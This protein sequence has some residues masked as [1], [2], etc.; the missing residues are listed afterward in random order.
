MGME[1]LSFSS[2]FISLASGYFQLG[3]DDF[4]RR[5]GKIIAHSE[6]NPLPA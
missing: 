6:E 3:K 1:Y 2:L 5:D 4:E